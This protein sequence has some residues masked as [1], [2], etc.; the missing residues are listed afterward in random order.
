MDNQ[1]HLESR[2]ARERSAHSDDD[3]LSK[4]YRLKDL[5]CHVRTSPSMDRCE[6]DFANALASIRNLEVLDLGCGNGE[7]SLRFLANGARV[8]GIDISATYVETARA[9]ARSR[10][11][12]E[13]RYYFNVMDAHHLQFP[14][15]TFDLVTGRGIL[16][17]L[18]VEIALKEIGRVL[19]KGG[20]AVFLEPLAAN[21]LLKLFR[22]LTPSARTEDERPLDTRDLRRIA[23]NWQ[24]ESTYYGFVT[25]PVAVVTSLLLRPFPNNLLLRAADAFERRVNRFDL[26][27]PFNQYVLLNLIRAT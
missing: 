16:H 21:P 14:D 11:F 27:Q 23:A 13:Q 3:V 5:F 1:T 25:A 15:D 4:S 9:E 7:Q 26:V 17:H 18:D 22:L 8:S 12:D 24:C 6:K 10:G 20:R 2:V 19:K